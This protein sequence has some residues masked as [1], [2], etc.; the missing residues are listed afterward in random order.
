[1][2]A[3]EADSCFRFSKTSSPM[4]QLKILKANGRRQVMQPVFEG[5]IAK[6]YMYYGE[7]NLIFYSQNYTISQHFIKFIHLRFS[8]E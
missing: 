5:E 8:K 2:D 1:M 3:K 4:G 6:K 7:E